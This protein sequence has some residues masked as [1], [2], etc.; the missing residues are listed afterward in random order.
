MVLSTVEPGRLVPGRLV[1][2]TDLG[3]GVSH[4]LR[5]PSTLKDHVMGLIDAHPEGRLVGVAFYPAHSGAEQTLDLW[6]LDLTTRGWH[7]LP[8]MPL[9]LG[10][11]KAQAT[12]T[13]A[14]YSWLGS[15]TIPPA[16]WSRFG[17]PASRGLRSAGCGSPS[18]DHP[19]DSVS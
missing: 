18:Q 1:A 14:C 19:A 6:L 7:Q 12:W 8:D 9:R 4:R 11:S 13:A 16:A 15:P 3:S 17:G 2:L 10:P 5:W